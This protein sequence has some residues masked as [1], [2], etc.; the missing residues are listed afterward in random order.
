MTSGWWRSPA[1]RSSPWPE[2]SSTASFHRPAPG[3]AQ[4]QRIPRQPPQRGGDP[5]CPGAFHRQR[6]EDAGMAPRRTSKPPIEVG[7]VL[8]LD[9]ADYKYGRG[10]LLVRVTAV[11]AVLR[12]ADGP[13]LH[14]RGDRLRD[15]GALL[16]ERE[17]FVRFDVARMRR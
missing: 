8:C 4:R 12:Q 1:R 9:E 10:A 13:W 5:A 6:R 3:Q 15:D 17:L 11:I 14:L 16:E 2:R 7:D